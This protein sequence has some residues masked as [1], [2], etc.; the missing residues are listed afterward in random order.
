MEEE[1]KK[2][3]ALHGADDAGVDRDEEDVPA[4]SY[5][6]TNPNPAFTPNPV[7]V[8]ASQEERD[9]REREFG[10][11][12]A[13]VGAEL[14]PPGSTERLAPSRPV[15]IERDEEEERGGVGLGIT[16]LVLSLL[17]L[18]FWPVVLG[19]AGIITGFFAY[20]RGS[21]G[22]GMWAM[23]IGALSIIIALFIVPFFT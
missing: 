4:P 7:N 23:G 16:A 9:E 10:T 12:D 13:E 11:N 6:V 1:R 14:A 2:T 19:A 17:S 5:T 20:R 15:G 3:E 8:R 21:V 18:L 22:L